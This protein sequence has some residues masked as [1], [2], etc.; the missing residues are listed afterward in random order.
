M[1]AAAVWGEEVREYCVGEEWRGAWDEASWVAY[2][3]S[4]GAVRVDEA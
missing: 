1:W 2:I 4:K 3:G